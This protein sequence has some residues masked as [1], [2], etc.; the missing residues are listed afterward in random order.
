MLNLAQIRAQKGKWPFES[1]S[2]QEPLE[3]SV[4]EGSHS[5]EHT[6]NY[7]H[8]EFEVNPKSV[9]GVIGGQST[10]VSKVRRGV[11]TFNRLEIRNPYGY[12]SRSG[13]IRKNTL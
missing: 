4:S 13:L 3:I 8:I 7:L 2:T 6:R 10:P 5:K 1:I 11:S 12:E 9:E